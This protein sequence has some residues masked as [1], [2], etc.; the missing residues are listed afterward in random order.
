MTNRSRVAIAVAA[1]GVAALSSCQTTPSKSESKLA[2]QVAEPTT[3]LQKEYYKVVEDRLGPIWYKLV[4]VNQEVADLGTVT[5]TFDIPA[6]GGK[7]QNVRVTSRR[8]I[9]VARA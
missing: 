5:V 3:P 8:S 7:A 6:A 4:A 9:G 2:R 1:V